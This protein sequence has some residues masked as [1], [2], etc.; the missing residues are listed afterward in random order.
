MYFCLMQE[1]VLHYLWKHRKYNTKN[2]LTVDHQPIEVVDPGIHNFNAGPDFLG[3]RIKVN[4]IEWNG[5]VEIHVKSSD[6]M[7]HQHQYDKAY[8]NVILH[9]VF[10]CDRPVFMESGVELIQ[11]EL[12]ERVEVG[13]L[14]K[15]EGFMKTK[16]QIACSQQLDG[17]PT[18]IVRQQLERALMSRLEN[19]YE[20]VKQE[21][22]KCQ[23][24]WELV[25][26]RHLAAAFG[27]NT[28]KFAFL[29]LAELVPLKIIQKEGYHISRVEALLFYYSGLLGSTGKNVYVE[30][31]SAIARQY[32]LKYSMEP[33]QPSEWKFATMRPTN[34]PTIRLAQWA[35]LIQ[36][37]YNLFSKI[38]EA[39]SYQEIMELLDCK[40]SEY[41]DNHFTFQK[42]SPKMEI[43]RAGTEF[44]QKLIINAVVPVLFAWSKINDDQQVLEKMINWL[45]QIPHEKNQIVSEFEKAGIKIQTAFESQAL[46][47]LKK[48]FCVPKKC[49]TCSIGIKVL[50][51][52]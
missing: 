38:K 34:F 23:G 51:K 49:L 47:E 40:A 50:Q 8:N 29:R 6:W 19:R 26:Y 10:E 3:A 44:V 27:T 2:L 4:G 14:S 37:Q 17:V 20:N 18:L 9:V 28:N 32:A 22:E 24:D 46:I 25:F 36:R 30:E 52:A 21:W 13:E 35:D 16:N 1:S 31:L 43:K 41:W 33:M 39:S 42:P 15:V 45:D 7:K 5:H 12:K 48:S 11:L